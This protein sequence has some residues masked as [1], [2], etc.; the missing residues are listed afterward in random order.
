MRMSRT[1]VALLAI[2]AL[3]TPAGLAATAAPASTTLAFGDYIVAS[4]ASVENASAVVVAAGGTVTRT[5]SNIN[6]LIVSLPERAAVALDAR[7]DMVVEADQ[8]VT[9]SDTQTETS[10]TQD[11]T[12]SWG[13][14]RV[15]EIASDGLASYTYP[16][17]QAGAGVVAY[18]VDTGVLASH[19]EFTG[20]MLGG[21]TAIGDGLGSTDCNGHGTHVAGT[22]AG[23]K[24]GIAP[25]ASVVPVRVLDC[26]GSGTY[27]GIISGIDWAVGHHTSAPAVMNMSLGGGASS[28]I[29]AA[30]DRAVA[31]GIVVVVAA[32]NNNDD[33]CRYSPASAPSAIT[34]GSTTSTD[35]RSSFSNYGTCVD[36]FAPGSGITS[37]W[38]TGTSATNTISGTSMASPHVAGVVARYLSAFPTATPATVASAL[39]AT[40]IL[41]KVTSPGT[42]SPNR[43]L[44]AAPSGYVTVVES[45][46]PVAPASVTASANFTSAT[47]SWVAGTGAADSG[48]T[49]YRVTA[50]PAT[51]VAISQDFAPSNSTVRLGG[52]SSQ[53]QY[54]ITVASVNSLTVSA[55]TSASG[56]VTT[57]TV[58]AEAPAMTLRSTSS[59]T[60][61]SWTAPRTYAPL[62]RYEVQWKKSGVTTWPSTWAS[63]GTSLS[64]SFSTSRYTLYDVRVR[65]VTVEGVG[66]I[67]TVLNYRT[68]R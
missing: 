1:A 6:M 50:T 37:A 28:T 24:Y 36:I 53:T 65:A 17:A 16:K 38:H 60:T 62:L 21:A 8:I 29:T 19:T 5:L 56:P 4:T 41:D 66:L 3:G 27:S 30:V 18:V 25:A 47:V 39:T 11:P 35:A 42:G 32:G 51:G 9:L 54:T 59:R 64:A 48:V 34:V 45:T 22:I 46:P 2:A 49:A 14:D 57:A 43:L 55:P 33:A 40:A 26:A 13:I 67:S 23:T 20:R 63:A 15:D 58:A 12:N 44:F 10:Y 68:A 61:V 31:D 52:L 7:P